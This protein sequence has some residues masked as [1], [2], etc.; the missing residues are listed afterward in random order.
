MYLK[1]DR[2]VVK[3]KDTVFR[4]FKLGTVPQFVLDPNAITGWTDGVG[5]RRDATVRPVSNGDFSEPY[6]MS[7]RL[8]SLTGSAVATTRQEL[9]DLRDTLTGLLQPNE[10]AEISV[11]TSAGTRY[12]T[13][14]M[15]GAV[16]FVQQLDNVASFKIDLYA[17]DPHIY[18][19]EK[20]QKAGSY[21]VSGGLEFPLAYPL[22]YHH[23]EDFNYAVIQNNGNAPSYPIIEVIGDFY[24]GFTIYDRL[25]GNKV[26]YTGMV[27]RQAPLLLDMARGTATQ[28]GVDKTVLVTE[29]GWFSIP[30][31]E[32][33][34]PIFAPLAGDDTG[35]LGWCDIIYRD[36]WL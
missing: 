20:R 32:S 10:Y 34:N 13:V 28:S 6:T 29:R 8:I 21:E 22:D 2:I 17:P 30:P 1:N 27:T 15:E 23:S 3:I 7:S 14:G 16:G 35:A 33:I 19:I 9:Q 36:T 26:T 12:S 5:V 11:E 31:K 4:S 25:G 24:S 18:G